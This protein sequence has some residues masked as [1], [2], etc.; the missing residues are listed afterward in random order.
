[1]SLHQFLLILLARKKI[2]LATL[3]T[4]VAL[5]LGVSLVLSKT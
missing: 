1:M 2:I 4:T 3:V 5:A